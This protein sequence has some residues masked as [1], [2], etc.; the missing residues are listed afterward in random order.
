MSN[1]INDRELQ[2]AMIK[3]IL[4]K[5]GSSKISVDIAVKDEFGDLFKNNSTSN[6]VKSICID[7]TNGSDNNDG[8]YSS[9]VKTLEKAWSMI[10]KFHKDSYEI[11]F[12]N[13][14]YF[15]DHNIILN[16]KF[17]GDKEIIFKTADGI[18]VYGELSGEDFTT[19]IIF[20]LFNSNIRFTSFESEGISFKFNKCKV[21]FDG[22]H[23]R[24]QHDAN[25][26]SST[27]K[28]LI[29]VKDCELYLYGDEYLDESERISFTNMAG[30]Q[31][32][33][34]SN[35][36]NIY[37]T[38]CVLGGTSG[39]SNITLNNWSNLR[40]FKNKTSLNGVL[41]DDTST[42]TELTV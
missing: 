11:E 8:S 40:I 34:Y 24:I 7:G 36:S 18:T 6:A 26:K 16:E 19:G 3:G 13:N 5:F 38:N 30:E 22:Q 2:T 1:I 23:S 42:I 15:I 17:I 10:P 12:I 41:K 28:S 35:Y 31:S 14:D 39:S 37:V 33:V 32:I 20:N 27:D 4:A 25:F 9:P 29:M 21:I